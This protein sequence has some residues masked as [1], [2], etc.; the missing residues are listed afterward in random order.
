MLQDGRL[1]AGHCRALLG[2]KE[3]SLIVPM[4]DR[5]VA[6]SLS[7]RETETAVKA[8]NKKRKPT[9]EEESPVVRVNYVAE[10]EHRVTSLTGRRCKILAK[11]N[12]KTLSIEYTDDADLENL[13]EKV[14]GRKVIED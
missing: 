4:A 12:K 5:I 6:H 7:V 10:L 14:C 8:Q 9:P 13:L 11:G 3:P 1:S 2:L